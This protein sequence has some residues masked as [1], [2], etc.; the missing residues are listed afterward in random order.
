MSKGKLFGIYSLLVLL[1]L[2]IT[3]FSLTNGQ[4]AISFE[5]FLQVVS[6]SGSKVQRL[7]I[8]DFRLPRII[9]AVLAGGAL[10]LSGT[11][12]Q[13]VTQNPLA[14]SGILGINAGAGFAVLLFISFFE[15]TTATVF[16]LPFVALLGALATAGSI[17]L[18]A[19]DRRKGLT[20]VRMVLT[21][22]VLSTGI[23]ALTILLT[24]KLDAENYRFVTMWQ[25]GT[26]WGSNW[27][28][29]GALLPWLVLVFVI[30]LRK[31]RVY[32][33]LQLGDETAISVGIEAGKERL[34]S[35]ILAVS[36]AAAAISVT[37]GISFLGL[38]APHIVRK[39]GA[40]KHK[41]ILPLSLLTGSVLLLL[42]DT[43]G[44]TIQEKGEI[45]AGVIVAII[46]APYFL[47]LLLR[48]DK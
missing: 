35:L 17:L 45:P 11:I 46:G 21:G 44:R 5:D 43:I 1:L 4:L 33:I 2:A 8:I 22:V 42:S 48:S 32:D 20:P 37:G 7:L 34:F 14:D 47:Y 26:I 6:G 29:A 18:I 19:Y 38:I 24:T 30:A 25:A 16:L 13:S 40:A 10:G 15:A 12:L 36:G 39:L 41:D 28:F 23:A 3:L 27:S 9:I 31:H